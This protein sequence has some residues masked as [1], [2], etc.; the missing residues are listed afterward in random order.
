[1]PG[2]ARDRTAADRQRRRRQRIEQ[3]IYV[4]QLQVDEADV[5]ALERPGLLKLGEGDNGDQ[6]VTRAQIGTAIEVLLSKL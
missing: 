2:I 5:R 4:V 1:M 6:R 3:G